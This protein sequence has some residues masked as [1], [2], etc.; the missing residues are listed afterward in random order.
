M[1]LDRIVQKE[2]QPVCSLKDSIAQNLHLIICSY[3]GEAAYSDEFGC[4]LWD[5]EFNIQ[6]N[7]RWRDELCDSIRRAVVRFE[8]RLL[9]PEV[10]ASMEELNEL[11]GKNLRVRRCLHIGID[12]VIRKTNEEF[13]FRDTIYISPVAQQ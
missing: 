12:G 7:P 4:S 5:E 13:H 1:R 9:L 3:R 10:K 11:I 8:P 2:R 6:Q